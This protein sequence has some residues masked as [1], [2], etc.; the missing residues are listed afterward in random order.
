MSR[1]VLKLSPMPFNRN[2]YSTKYVPVFLRYFGVYMVSSHVLSTHSTVVVLVWLTAPAF[3]FLSFCK[4]TL[5]KLGHMENPEWC[6]LDPK[7]YPIWRI[8]FLLFTC[9]LG[10]G[11][12]QI[13]SSALCIITT[14]DF[15]HL[16]WDHF[17]HV[18][19]TSALGHFWWS[20]FG[21]IL[22]SV[23]IIPLWGV[24]VRSPILAH[25]KNVV[26]TV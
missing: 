16:R 9:Q 12:F 3:I 24:W 11:L 22:T 25:F 10:P 21:Y 20:H 18:I 19:T 26:Y 7:F 8:Y 14:P 23:G 4:A 2:L 17:S 15:D 6:A 1:D 5:S 13:V